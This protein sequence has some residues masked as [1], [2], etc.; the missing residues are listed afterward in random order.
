MK[1][2]EALFVIRPDASEEVVSEVTEK[3][4][5]Q[6]TRNG[7]IVLGL[8]NWG[9]KKLAYEINHFTEGVYIKMD[10][11]APGDVIDKLSRH[12]VMTEEVVRYQTTRQDEK[13]TAAG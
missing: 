5:L 2:Y 1:K 13:K 6:V 11:E 10:F 4:Q 9:R 8:E 3:A 7:G 12:F